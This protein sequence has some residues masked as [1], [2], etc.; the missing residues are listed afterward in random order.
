MT[1]TQRKTLILGISCIVM[2]LAALPGLLLAS[3]DSNI[4]S[5]KSALLNPKYASDVNEIKLS[6]PDGQ[7]FLFRKQTN[8]LKNECWLCT[9]SEGISF[10][11]NDTIIAQLI[12]RASGT[13]SMAEVSDS[14]TAWSALGLSDDSAIG[15]EFSCSR[16]DGSSQVFS[17]LFFGF[18]NADG[19]M[20]YVRNDRKSSSW[21]I[22]NA[23]SSYL[24]DSYASWSSQYLL[25]VGNKSESDP[26]VTRIS[27]RSSEEDRV[28]YNNADTAA[29]FDD[30]VHTLLSLRSSDI[31]SEAEFIHQAPQAVPVLSITLSGSDGQYG[32]VV[33][34]AAFEDGAEVEYYVR[35][36][37]ILSDAESSY[38]QKISS[39]TFGKLLET[40]P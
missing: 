17:S 13:V 8:L 4:T 18:E 31:M 21:R 26:T 1:R 29:S 19:S 33:Y 27:I 9:T 7:Q 34:Q 24:T 16:A 32:L 35:N 10:P 40:A 11:A 6:F 5:V 2:A 39:W 23:Y 12:E 22:S 38:V 28:M 30:A 14:Y 3:H 15:M 20:I 25:P 36:Y 37:G